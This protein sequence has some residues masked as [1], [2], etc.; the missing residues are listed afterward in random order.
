MKQELSILAAWLHDIGKFAQRAD[1]PCSQGLAQEYCPHGTT[2]RHV[3][4]TDYFIEHV[5]PLPPDLEGMRSRLARLASAHHRPDAT[6]R[7]ELFLQRADHL[8]S[9]GDRLEGEAEGD[10]RTARLESVFTNV[11]LNGKGLAQDAPPLRYRL[12]PLD[13]QPGAGDDSPLF[14]VAQ[15]GKAA[16]YKALY[17]QFL[18]ALDSLPLHMGHHHYMAS[19]VSLLER[20]TWC[21]PSSTWKTRADISLYDHAATT[22]AI[23]QALLACPTGKERLLLAGGELSGIQRFIFGAE[24]QADKGA[25]KLLRARSLYLQALTRSVWLSLLERLDLSPAARIMDAGG[26][27]VLL[28]PDTPQSRE[29]LRILHQEVDAWL[30][31]TFLG[32]ARMTFASLPLLPEDLERTRFCGRF[33][34]FN[35]ALEEAKLHPFA[36]AFKG[37]VS[38]VLG[39]QQ[40]D[41]A[42]YGE[43]DFCRARPATGRLDD[44][45]PICGLCRRLIE[46]VG[47]RLPNAQYL[48]FT[49]EGDGVA[50]FDGLR[51]RLA[52]RD[53]ADDLL[54]DALDV[55]NMRG[56]DG[57]AA[58]PVAGHVPYLTRE[59]M[60]RWRNEG[61]LEDINGAAVLNGE[62]VEV[63]APKTF[64]ML[65][66][67]ARVPI[68]D[69]TGMRSVACLAACKADV[70]NLGLLFGMGF[71]TGEESLFSIS[72]FAMLSRM[73]NHFFAAHAPRLMKRE[74]PGMYLVFAGGD[75]LFAL[76]PWSQA[77]D[78]AR[79]LREDFGRFTGENPAVTFSAGLPVFKPRLPMRAIRRAAE[80][81]LEASKHHPDKDAATLF[82]V[83]AGWAQCKHLL[84]NGQWLEDMCL[85]GAVT[86]GFVRRLLGYARACGEFYRGDMR[87][88]LYLAHLAY[89]MKRNCHP[90]NVDTERLWRMAQDNR[91]FPQE[92]LGIT[93]ALYRTRTTGERS[94]A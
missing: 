20:F 74:F 11:C 1:A 71:G 27:F 32:T 4:Y 17:A 38:P 46:Q 30:L 16:S 39:V 75:D 47:R 3:L 43:C 57:F 8:S 80:D 93:W 45:A 5:L 26:R 86:Q 79:R 88:G 24:G 44:G 31:K 12:L 7:E 34:A 67:E 2:H 68:A 91:G 92:E 52:A 15:A 40:K 77:I 13:T 50:L 28:L 18:A 62:A 54:R 29:T 55:V 82:G 66:E 69:S 90:D 49:R 87:K 37:G 58:V 63:D 42:E 84:E 78:F 23:V 14:P 61:R 83:T 22:A 48:V 85:K 9:G 65:A 6:S 35:D 53:A 21:V 41:Y 25:S 64:A 36:T 72:R 94:R 70:D 76:G 51:L 60:E 59:D 56:Y 10:F 89:D 73:M 33:E 19:L 81:A